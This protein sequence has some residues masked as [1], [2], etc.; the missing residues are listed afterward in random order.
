MPPN[1]QFLADLV[2]FTEEILNGKLHFL[3]SDYFELYWKRDYKMP[4]YFLNH[5]EISSSWHFDKMQMLLFLELRTWVPIWVWLSSFMCN[6]AIL[7][8]SLKSLYILVRNFLFVNLTLSMKCEL[9]F[10]PKKNLQ[11]WNFWLLL[12]LWKC[13]YY[14]LLIHRWQKS[15]T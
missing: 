13:Y 12:R 2:T 9:R 4:V 5:F 10:L 15:F 11:K 7:Y 6:V 14:Y 8:L 1:P 3:C